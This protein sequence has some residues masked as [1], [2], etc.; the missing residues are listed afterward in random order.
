MSELMPYLRLLAER[1][2]A[3]AYREV[4]SRIFREDPV[5]A[6]RRIMDRCEKH[7]ARFT[8]FI[9]GVC[10]QR[11][12]AIMEEIL[13][14]GHEIAC[15]GYLHRRF[16]KLPPDSVR[17]DIERSVAYFDKTFNYRL[18][19]FRAP[20]LEMADFVYPI[21]KE[22][23]FSYSSSTIGN[24]SS[25]AE[26]HG[27]VEFPIAIDD[28]SVL[29]KRNMGVEE[30][31]DEMVANLSPGSCFL[32]HPWRVGQ[33]R[34]VSAL[35]RL[36]ER[37]KGAWAFP[38]MRDMTCGAPAIALSGDIGELGWGELVSRA[39]FGAGGKIPPGSRHY[40]GFL[41]WK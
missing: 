18:A 15:H 23:G 12:P 16:N 20:Y 5:L 6:T 28:W 10:A 38:A 41:R 11:N 25:I 9:V 22:M 34:I 8:F 30:L 4:S 24:A 29:I 17:W 3:I 40:P 13:D 31:A 33:E 32:L 37:G 19:G 26:R 36:F 35:D 2:P 21:L 39:L 7:G 14:R 1:G 27:I